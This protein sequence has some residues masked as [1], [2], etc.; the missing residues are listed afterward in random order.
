MKKIIAVIGSPNY[1]RSN[2]V[3]L[4]SDFLQEVKNIDP[5][6]EYEVISLG[7]QDIKPCQGCWACMK[8]GHCVIKDDLAA[9]QAKLLA[10]DLVIFGSPVYAHQVSG[11][12]KTFIDR[13]FIWIHT[14][15]LMGIPALS[16]T[17]TAQTGTTAVQRSLQNTLCMMGAV[18]VG[19]LRGIAYRPGTFPRRDMFRLKHLPLAKKV[20]GILQGRKRPMAT[21]MNHVYFHGLQ[22]SYQKKAEHLPYEHQ[23]WTA[24]R[25]FGCGF[26]QARKRERAGG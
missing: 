6:V 26:G 18:P 15:K 13:M 12:M 9:I 1:D 8:L 25:W 17:T 3:C 7:A 11:Q 23:Y 10:S 20:V 5:E 2:T 24:K 22:I 14:M 4:T 16:A 21:L 19:K